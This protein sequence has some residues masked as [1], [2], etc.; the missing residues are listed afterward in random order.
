MPK[1]KDEVMWDAYTGGGRDILGWSQII[2]IIGVAISLIP[3]SIT[4]IAYN[5]I[6]TILMIFAPVF[7][8]FSI[9]PGRGRKIFL[10][11]LESVLSYILKY[12]AIGILLII[13]VAVYQA[14]FVNTSGH[15]TLIIPLILA[16]VFSMYRKEVV[17]LIGTV[18][19]GGAKMKNV[20]AEKM[21][22]LS[23]S[24]KNKAKGIT[25]AVAGGYLGGR[26]AAQDEDGAHPGESPEERARRYR[27]AKAQ[28]ITS[29]LGIE[30]RRGRG[31]VAN[32]ARA[33]Q[34][35]KRELAR[36][37]EIRKERER[38]AKEREAEKK[39]KDKEKEEE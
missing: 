1:V 5:I 22:R 34:Q 2:G 27:A 15:M 29:A 13:M 6:S 19:L 32:A 23:Q 16:V 7:L 8:L 24:T 21:G 39:K 30:M 36:E 31:F 11:W 17:N 20:A 12:F 26:M 4:G 28:G 3:V 38:E 18:S 10:G 14:A 25:S 9:H 33:N 37:R 35:V